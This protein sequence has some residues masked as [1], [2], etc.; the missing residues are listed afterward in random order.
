CERRL[1]VAIASLAA[2]I[3]LL[4]LKEGRS[5]TTLISPSPRQ[6]PGI[7]NPDGMGNCGSIHQ[8]EPGS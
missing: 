2:G 4:V 1:S 8:G 3:A 7:G 5:P 6:V